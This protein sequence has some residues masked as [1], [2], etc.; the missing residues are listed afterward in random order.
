LLPTALNLVG[1]VLIKT[2][3]LEVGNASNRRFQKMFSSNFYDL[4]FPNEIYDKNSL[5]FH[6]QIQD[7]FE[8]S[9]IFCQEFA[10]IPHKQEKGRRTD[11]NLVAADLA[12]NYLALSQAAKQPQVVVINNTGQREHITTVKE[13]R[14]EKEEKERYTNQAWMVLLLGSIGVGLWK[15]ADSTGQV[16]YLHNLFELLDM[17]KS[18]VQCLDYWISERKKLNMLVPESI[19]KDLIQLEKVCDNLEKLNNKQEKTLTRNSYGILTLSA[20]LVLASRFQGANQLL[21][22]GFAGLGIGV[23]SWIYSKAFYSSKFHQQSL[24]M[25][26]LRILGDIAE[27]KG[28]NEKRENDLLRLQAPK[29]PKVSSNINS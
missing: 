26:A 6:S 5:K 1:F 3:L 7:F 23:C 14:L 21:N 12:L 11:T 25:I 19:N 8:F 15:L 22:I 29:M 24:E 10:A 18:K 13:S 2:G 16:E 27:M 17:V 9:K 28:R 20:G 4:D